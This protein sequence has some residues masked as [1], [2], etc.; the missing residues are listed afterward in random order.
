[1]P[2]ITGLEHV[3]LGGSMK[4]KVQLLQTKNKV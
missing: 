4:A 1:M 2:S 3:K